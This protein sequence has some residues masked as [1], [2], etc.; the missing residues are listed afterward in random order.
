MT[1]SLHITLPRKHLDVETLHNILINRITDQCLHT[2]Y[3]CRKKIRV[4][5][6]RCVASGTTRHS[7]S[8]GGSGQKIQ[9][10]LCCKQRWETSGGPS[11]SLSSNTLWSEGSCRGKKFLSLYNVIHQTLN[12]YSEWSSSMHNYNLIHNFPSHNSLYMCNI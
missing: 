8:W 1:N 11:S 10:P 7:C 5:S 4:A 6:G 9:L 12:V 3:T 2:L